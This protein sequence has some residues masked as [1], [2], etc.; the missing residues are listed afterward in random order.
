MSQ[1]PQPEAGTGEESGLQR[2]TFTAP[3]AC[4]H[5]VGT[6][7]PC[8]S[9]CLH[10]KWQLTPCTPSL[11]SPHFL[12]LAPSSGKLTGIR[13]PVWPTHSQATSSPLSSGCPRFS[14]ALTPTHTPSA[15]SQPSWSQLPR[16][17]SPAFISQVSNSTQPLSFSLM[18]APQRPP[19][20][21]RRAGA[22]TAWT[23]RRRQRGVGS[24]P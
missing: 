7:R 15:G 19:P 8:E 3:S 21:P 16:T 1:P 22:G 18:S 23:R 4:L 2:A 12:P 9:L 11:N 13:C 20:S 10:S 24:L 5:C 14:D 17:P 6:G